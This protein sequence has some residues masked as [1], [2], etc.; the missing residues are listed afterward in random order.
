LPEEKVKIQVLVLSFSHDGNYY[1]I[2]PGVGVE[3]YHQDQKKALSEFLERI[4]V[5]ADEAQERGMLALFADHAQERGDYT[6]PD[7]ADQ[8]AEQMFTLE[9]ESEKNEPT[10]K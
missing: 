3:C 10:G 9:I 7:G 8:V 4:V 5:S 1:F 2:A 6:L